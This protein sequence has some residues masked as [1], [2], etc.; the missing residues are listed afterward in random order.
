MKYFNA[1]RS[2]SR[3]LDYLIFFVALALFNCEGEVPLVKSF[4]IKKGE[5]YSTERAPETLQ[6][7]RMMFEAKFNSTA[8]YDLGDV[9]LQSNKNK[10]LGFSDCNSLHHQNSARFGW[11]WYNNRLEIFAYC[12][13]NGAR[14][15]K[16]VGV[17]NLDE[18]NTYE[19]SIT[20]DSYIFRLN[21]SEPVSVSRGDVCTRGIFYKLW[22][23]FGGS[24]AAP[25]DIVIL[26]RQ[27]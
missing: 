2:K 6:D 13:V 21:N 9:A 8:K 5:H 20:D 4:T 26:V 18:F 14:I 15:E 24:I 27:N 11:Q 3:K 25:H 7:S 23:Y 16:Y 10:L 19:I 17:V 12:Y 1:I 22:P